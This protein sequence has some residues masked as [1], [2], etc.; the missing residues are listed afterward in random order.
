MVFSLTKQAI[1][2]AWQGLGAGGDGSQG[3]NVGSH[4]DKGH[5]V[6]GGEGSCQGSLCLNVFALRH[7][8]VS[9][10][11]ACLHAFDACVHMV[12][13]RTCAFDMYLCLA[14]RVPV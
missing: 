4:Q 5:S 14:H 11:R 10:S 2:P 9:M 7:V 8:C 6:L 1:P 13:E 3:L 12:S